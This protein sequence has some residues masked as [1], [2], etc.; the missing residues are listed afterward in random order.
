MKRPLWFKLGFILALAAV[1][2]YSQLSESQ[3]RYIAHLVKQIPFMPAR[4]CV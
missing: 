4:Y 3:R 2:V 1:L